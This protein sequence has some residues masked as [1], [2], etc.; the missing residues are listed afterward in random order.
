MIAGHER[1]VVRASAIGASRLSWS[2][3]L[4]VGFTKFERTWRQI[5]QVW[6][7]LVTRGPGAAKLGV[8]LLETACRYLISHGHFYLYFT[9][10]ERPHEAQFLEKFRL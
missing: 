10:V 7:N 4:G 1:R 9:A 2:A 6:E 5:N 8:A 3:K